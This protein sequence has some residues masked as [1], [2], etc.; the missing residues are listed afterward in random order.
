MGPEGADKLKNG[1][2][3][4]SWDCPFNK[5]WYSVFFSIPSKSDASH[6]EVPV[7]Y[8]TYKNSNLH[9]GLG[10]KC[11]I[12]NSDLEKYVEDREDTNQVHG[13]NHRVQGLKN[14][15]RQRR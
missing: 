5:N 7:R 10:E 2:T 12:D 11:K 14:K 15:R 3:K 8:P 9:W 1:I 4:I 13:A 6:K